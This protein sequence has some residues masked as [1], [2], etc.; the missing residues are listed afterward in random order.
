MKRRILVAGGTGLLGEPV[1][2]RLHEDGFTVRVLA[3]DP[4]RARR[5]FGDAFEI[6][7]ADITDLKA[8]ERSLL[9]CWGAHISIGGA[10]DQVSAENV[11]DLALATGL[12]RVGY[13]SGSTVCEE[14]GWFPMVAQKLMAEKA[15]GACG[16]PFTIFCPTW[17][18]ETLLRFVRGG[19]ATLI[20]KQPTPYHFFAAED[21]AR[22]VSRAYRSDEAA[23]KRLYV[24][25]PEAIPMRVALER[26]CAALYPEIESVSVLPIGLARIMALLTRNAGLKYATEL[27]AYFDKAGEPG[28]PAE[29]NRL[30]GAPTLTLEQWIA[31]RLNGA[32]AE[33]EPVAAG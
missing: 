22:M 23:N 21:L 26:V 15:V 9:G 10:V 13:I 18:F 3:R 17:P 29:A 33:S 19:R 1:A 11:A 12:Q 20:G 30:L 25:G 31:K 2:R 4:E 6:V 16:A 28:D 24:H 8:L 7:A 5:L 32:A 27:M 14:N